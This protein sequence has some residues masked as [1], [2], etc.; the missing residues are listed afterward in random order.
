MPPFERGL[1]DRAIRDA[2]AW[3]AVRSWVEK[4]LELSTS[5]LPLD[6]WERHA[7]L[8]NEAREIA[9]R[10]WFARDITKTKEWQDAGALIERIVRSC[11]HLNQ[12]LKSDEI[13][14]DISMDSSASAEIWAE[15]VEQV[16]RK[17]SELIAEAPRLE[18]VLNPDDGRVLLYWPAE[19]L[20]CGA[21]EV[22]S[23]GFFD[24]DN[25]PPWDIWVGF[26]ERTL[27]SWVPPMLVD[28]VQMGIDAN[29]EQCIQWAN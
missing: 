1:F 6:L 29:P 23:K 13:K 17:R 19:N 27:V 5:S 16:V 25:V 21:A 2:A 9:N 15:G 10:N 24:A 3:C 14:P 8:L 4:Y 20:A 26:S 11:G 12:L 7:R 22:A 18:G 28:V